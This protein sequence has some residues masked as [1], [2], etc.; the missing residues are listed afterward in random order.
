M[1]QFSPPQDGHNTA[2]FTEFLKNR[3]K[4]AN[5]CKASVS[6]LAQSKCSRSD[7]CCWR[8]YRPRRCRHSD[9][10][11]LKYTP[12]TRS[13][14]LCVQFCVTQS[15][16]NSLLGLPVPAAQPFGE[17]LR[18]EN[19]RWGEHH[20]AKRLRPRARTRVDSCVPGLRWLAEP[21]VPSRGQTTDLLGP[22]PVGCMCGSAQRRRSTARLAEGPNPSLS[23]SLPR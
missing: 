4:E 22:P 5:A 12:R 21:S 14:G 15:P 7:E 13:P 18:R 11:D 9:T 23:V 1:P 8:L 10:F 2:N 16:A 17:P 6:F 20:T 3:C 19:R